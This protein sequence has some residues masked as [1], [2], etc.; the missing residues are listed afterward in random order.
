MLNHFSI[1][2]MVAYPIVAYIALWFEQPYFVIGYLLLILT[3]MA[4]AKCQSR[5]WTSGIVLFTT[6]AIIAYFTQ[7]TNAEYLVYFPPILLLLSMFIFFSQSLLN[8]QI[9]VIARYAQMI[10]DKLEA[11][12][13]RYYRSLTILWSVFM[14]LMVI[15]SIL[16]AVFSSLDNWSL[17]THV[18]SY[19]LIASFFIIEFIYRKRRFNGE[20]ESNFFR[21]IKKIIKIRP[22]NLTK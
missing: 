19:L 16:L 9:P 11:H 4:L 21:F 14:L 1:T 22:H 13:L 18:I 15:T 12:H 10:G 8:G 5:H 6:I 2:L 7:Q 17:F 20:L 3:L